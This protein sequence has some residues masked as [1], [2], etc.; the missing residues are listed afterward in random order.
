[1]KQGLCII[2][3][4][5]D[6]C[7]ELIARYKNYSL[8]GDMGFVYRNECAG[9]KMLCSGLVYTVH[10]DV[11]CGILFW[12][13]CLMCVL[14]KVYIYVFYW[15]CSLFCANNRDVDNKLQMFSYIYIHDTYIYIYVQCSCVHISTN[16]HKEVFVILCKVMAVQTL[17]FAGGRIG[18]QYRLRECRWQ[19]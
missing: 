14:N 11:A 19:L 12:R 5:S 9:N 13:N 18:L 10:W 1:M 15:G 3:V 8:R 16:N 2:H 17:L 7:Y 6:S 4:I